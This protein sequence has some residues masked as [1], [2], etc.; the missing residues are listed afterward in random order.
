M[1]RAKIAPVTAETTAISANLDRIRE[2]IAAAA[3]RARRRPEEITLVGVSKT[4]PPEAIVAAH[5]LGLR[6]FGENRVQEFEGKQPKLAELD[7][8]WH[9][10]GHLQRNKARR[11]VHLF[12]CVDGVDSLSL[13][14]VLESEAAAQG[15]RVPILIEVRLSDE[16]TKT[17]VAE[18]NVLALAESIAPL[19]NLRLR[20]LMMVPPYF[21]DPERARPYFRKLRE[22]KDELSRRLGFPPPALSMGMS[23][24]FEIAI[25]EG[26]TEIR[27][28]TALFGARPP[29]KAQAGLRG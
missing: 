7:A 20:G 11:A 10:I 16:P 14:Q 29:A 12:H 2:R 18:A 26:A 25:E 15:K 23:H 5:E 8:E 27:L 13:A 4:F 17:G 6:H 1:A 24:D 19:A 21:E 22:I 28:G 9:F 3:E